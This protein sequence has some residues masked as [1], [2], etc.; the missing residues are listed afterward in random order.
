MDARRRIPSTDALLGTAE[1]TA[2][3]ERHGRDVVKRA[4]GI[5]QRRVR[6]GELG[7]DQILAAVLDHLP[8]R[9]RSIEPVINATG[10]VVHMNLG[11]APLSPA[12]RAAIAAATGY[13]SVELAH[14]PTLT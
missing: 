7:P 5:A 9:E 1:L 11:R 10:I 8:R 2:A 4:V 14:A 13:T 6:D 12:A 3:A